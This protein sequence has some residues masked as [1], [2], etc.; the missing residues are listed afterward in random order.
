M[1]YIAFR[2]LKA[3]KWLEKATKWLEKATKKILLLL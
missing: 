1:I 2:E 3:T